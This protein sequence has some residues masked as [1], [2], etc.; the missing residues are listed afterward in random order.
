[1][2]PTEKA[3]E[4]VNI[5]R[6]TLQDLSAITTI[7]NDAIINT[8]ATFDIEPKS[9]EEQLTWFNDHSGK[10]IIM[11]AEIAD[12]VVGWASLSR[13]SDRCAYSD[14]AECSLYIENGHRNHGIGRKLVDILMNEARVSGIHTLIVRITEGNEVSIHMC[15]SYGFRHIG[16]MKEVGRKFGRLQ[17]VHLM[18]IIFE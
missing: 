2:S 18:Q 7:Y 12:K 16:I 14:T 5:R 15:E 8:V 3:T 1:M 13:W 17:D 9:R 4:Q 11:V 10:Y 6:A